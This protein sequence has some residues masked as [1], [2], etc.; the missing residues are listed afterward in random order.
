MCLLYDPLH[1]LYRLSLSTDCIRAIQ[2]TLIFFF[3]IQNNPIGN[4]ALINYSAS[5]TMWLGRQERSKNTEWK[6]GH[7][8]SNICMSFYLYGF[9][10]VDMD[11]T[12]YLKK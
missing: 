9:Q 8:S 3:S 4:T 5:R 11:L 7:K 2:N 12:V 1:L 6:G 10:P